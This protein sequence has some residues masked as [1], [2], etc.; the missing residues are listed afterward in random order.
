MTLEEGIR[1]YIESKHSRGV[2][3]EKEGSRLISF[4]RT[5]GNLELNR[6]T[7]SHIHTFLGSR[8]STATTWNLKRRM[9][10]N[11]FS[12][13]VVRRE[14]DEL[15]LPAQKPRSAEIFVPYIYTRSE[16]RRLLQAV[17]TATR[18]RDCSVEAKTFQTF[19]LFLYG[20]GALVGEAQRLLH[21]DLDLRNAFVTMHDVRGSRSR[22]IPI[23][24]DLL[25]VLRAYSRTALR[26]TARCGPFFSGK[27]GKVIPAVTITKTFERVRRIAGV[28]REDEGRGRFQPRMHDLRHSFAVHRLT[29]WLN[30]GASV[31]RLL[32]A[33]SAYIGQVHLSSTERYLR[34]APERFRSQLNALSPKRADGHWRDDLG[35]M[36]FL[37][38]L[39]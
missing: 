11:F 27:G 38:S 31:P 6:I 8:D 16:I 34:L 39:K 2:L 1:K 9:L 19:L 21:T 4:L 14:M 17:P 15:S 36:T 25:K 32:P 13:W 29:S 7:H 35:L 3:F 12:Y 33:L 20:T 23:G 26:R 10:H 37:N 24:A 18:A 5:I 22:C 28:I 30:H